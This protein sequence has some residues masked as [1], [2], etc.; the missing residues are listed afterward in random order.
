[1]RDTP[2]G[3]ARIGVLV[4]PIAGVGGPLALHG[5]DRDLAAKALGLGAQPHSAER[6]LSALVSL[7][8]EVRGPLEVVAGM[9]AMGE[10]AAREAGLTV[11]SVLPRATAGT[12]TSAADTRLAADLATKY[13]IDLLLFAGGDGTATDVAA[14]VG[15]GTP[16]LGVPSGVKMHSGVFAI[17]PERAGRIAATFLASAPPRSTRTAEVLDVGVDDVARPIGHVVTPRSPGIQSPKAVSRS[18]DGAVLALGHELADA[19]EPGRLYLIGPG[20]SAGTV[21]NALSLDGSVSGVDAVIDG[22]LVARD[23]TERDLLD[24]VST[25]TGARLVL[26]VVGGQGFLLGRGNQQISRRV[27]A[28]IEPDDVIIVAAHDK[29]AALTPPVLHIDMGADAGELTLQGYR[30]VRTSPT[31]SI[32]MHVG[33]DHRERGL[34]S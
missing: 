14:A 32:V 16:V 13:P 9:G 23:A 19:M 17:D 33:I 7:R 4:N 2:V 34:A 28:H 18:S 5:S 12:R 11:V 10:D 31:R 3:A 15:D 26:G 20:M 29:I 22:R 27:L 6:M 21:L 8:R 30:K 25:H 24:L 1:V